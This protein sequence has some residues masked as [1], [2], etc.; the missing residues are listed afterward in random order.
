MPKR[1]FTQA[2][3]HKLF[4]GIVDLNQNRPKD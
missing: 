4:Y 1:E 2:K 3:R